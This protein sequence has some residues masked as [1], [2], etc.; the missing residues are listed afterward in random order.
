MP[1]NP[2]SQIVEVRISE[3]PLY[4]NT[5]LTSIQGSRTGWLLL[6]ILSFL[7]IG[8]ELQVL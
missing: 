8:N 4:F 6:H 7:S 1:D 3:F 2:S 5:T